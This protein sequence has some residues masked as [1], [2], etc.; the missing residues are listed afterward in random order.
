MTI[1]RLR[2]Y[3]LACPPHA[4]SFTTQYSSIFFRSREKGRAFISKSFPL[5][6]INIQQAQLRKQEKDVS[7]INAPVAVATVNK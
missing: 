1:L 7:M 5:N 3:L 2:H 4:Q 6:M